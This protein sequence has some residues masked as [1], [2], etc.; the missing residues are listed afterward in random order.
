VR[1]AT[2]ARRRLLAALLA[3]VAT[4]TAIRAA[5]APGEPTVPVVVARAD[6][7]GG[8]PLGTA[9]V[10][11]RALGEGVAPAGTASDPAAVVGRL[12]AAPVRR[13][14]PLTDVRLVTPDLLDGYPGLVAAPVRVADAGVVGLLRVGDRVDLVASDP[15]GERAVTVAAGA[16]V[17]ALPADEGDLSAGGSL[18]SGGLV[19]VAVDEEVAVTL[20]RV[21]VSSVLSVI[22]T[23]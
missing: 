22:L 9:D 10:E 1:R 8:R 23:G 18:L 11:V 3:G 5:S 6:L 15:G 20:A 21:S 13:G 2:L 16:P 12:L 19:V 17:V 7:A 4:L 14:E